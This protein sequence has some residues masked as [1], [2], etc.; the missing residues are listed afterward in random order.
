[1]FLKLRA[2]ARK[3]PCGPGRM[4]CFHCKQPKVPANCEADYVPDGPKLGTLQ[5]L[6]PV[7]TPERK[8]GAMGDEEIAA[9]QEAGLPVEY[10]RK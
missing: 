6:C 1:M 9:A 2:A 3:Q 10:G 8:R 4:Y 7:S 5:G